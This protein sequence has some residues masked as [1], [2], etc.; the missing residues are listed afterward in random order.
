[1]DVERGSPTRARNPER[2]NAMRDD[3]P[4]WGTPA[5]HFHRDGDSILVESSRAGG[6]YVVSGTALALLKDADEQQ[7]ARLTT[8]LVR[9]RAVGDEWPRVASST[10]DEVK[11]RPASSVVDRADGILRF[12]AS[13]TGILGASVRFR[14][15]TW[16]QE[17]D[18]LTA[19]YFGLL[20]HS[21]CVG[22]NDLD[23]LLDYLKELGFIRRDGIN[24]PEQACTL[25]V[26]G[27]S[28]LAELEGVQSPSKRAFVAMWFDRSMDEAWRNG[29]RVA[30][31]DAG[32][33]PVRID[34]I[35]HVNKIDDEI[36][37]EIRRSR[38][39]V[40]DFTHGD[41]GARGGVYYE[42]GFAHGL[43][44]P[45]IFCCRKAEFEQV[46]FD[47]RQYNHIVWETPAELHRKLLARISAVIGDGPNRS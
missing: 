25:T 18:E 24:N 26:G 36:V 33:E 11:S 46:H 13:R 15:Q 27:Y 17:H 35:E 2:V 21:E 30:I 38:F 29:F 32:Y 45:V 6:K 1:L 9:Q 10:L 34:Q 28:R 31:E 42:A 41:E 8:R 7:K 39:L 22:E 4:I 20:A 40:A 12:L 47:T 16:S 37:A 5:V 14:F 3:C 44:I 19:N 23:F 43:N